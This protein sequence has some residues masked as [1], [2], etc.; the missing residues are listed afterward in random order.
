[1]NKI[2]VVTG[3]E[4]QT[5]VEKYHTRTVLIEHNLAVCSTKEHADE[6]ADNFASE[7]DKYLPDSIKVKEYELVGQTYHNFHEEA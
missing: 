3:N 2:Y 7:N 1:M 6:L 5:H 4:Y